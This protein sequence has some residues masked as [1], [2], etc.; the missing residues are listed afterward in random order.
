MRLERPRIWRVW[1]ST[2]SFPS[3]RRHTRFARRFC[4]MCPI[5]WT[6]RRL[7]VSWRVYCR[8]S[9]RGGWLSWLKGGS[10]G[11][12]Q[13]VSAAVP[14][15]AW[16]ASLKLSNA[17]V[18]KY[19]RKARFVLFTRLL[20]RELTSNYIYRWPVP[21]DSK[22]PRYRV[23][24]WSDRRQIGRHNTSSRRIRTPESLPTRTFIRW[25]TEKLNLARDG[26]SS[27][28]SRSNFGI[29]SSSCDDP[30]LFCWR[31]VG[32]RRMKDCTEYTL[33]ESTCKGILELV[34]GA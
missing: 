2:T 29:A 16:R 28:A 32:T 13:I 26:R 33:P 9:P 18:C 1:T 31:R 5:W 15:G 20:S 24:V 30:V 14:G 11:S 25:M 7:E 17:S 10:S 21:P 3:S 22:N 27:T 19:R 4:V 12:T 34:V 8:S 23:S 6:R